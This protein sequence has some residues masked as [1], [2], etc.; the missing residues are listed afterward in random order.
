MLDAVGISVS[1]GYLLSLKT[2]FG[3]YFAASTLPY[4]RAMFYL[5]TPNYCEIYEGLD[6]EFHTSH[7]TYAS[8]GTQSCPVSTHR[9]TL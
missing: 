9:F 8:M 5:Y 2:W 4:G 3:P 1:L 7:Y 6:Q